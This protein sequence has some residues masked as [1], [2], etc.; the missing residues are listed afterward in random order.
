MLDGNQR[1]TSNFGIF[2]YRTFSF[3]SSW[4]PYIIFMLWKH[5]FLLWVCDF[6]MW[7]TK[8]IVTGLLSH[9]SKSGD[10]LFTRRLF[11]IMM[12]ILM[13]APLEDVKLLSELSFEVSVQFLP[14]YCFFDHGFSGFLS[15][16]SKQAR[17]EKKKKLSTLSRSR[18]MPLDRL[19]IN[20][21]KLEWMMEWVN[22]WMK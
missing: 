13:V 6:I 20:V 11:V 19:L 22:K 18:R 5:N 2:G 3:L 15:P 4:W 1:Q 8:F 14:P 7:S 17:R 10:L 16:S 9:L 21:S 12:L